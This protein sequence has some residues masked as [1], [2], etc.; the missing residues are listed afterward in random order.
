MYCK[1][2]DTCNTRKEFL[3]LEDSNHTGYKLHERKNVCLMWTAPS[4]KNNKTIPLWNLLGAAG[5]RELQKF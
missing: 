1:N 5:G 2:K 3:N 4:W